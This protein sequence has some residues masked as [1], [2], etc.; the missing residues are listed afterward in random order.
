MLAA[1][2]PQVR[3][4]EIERHLRAPSGRRQG[5]KHPLIRAWMCS[6]L[7]AIHAGRAS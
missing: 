1:F 6:R 3:E 4:P 2:P 5:A 7:L